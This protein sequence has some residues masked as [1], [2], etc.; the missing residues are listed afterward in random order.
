MEN[1]KNM[2][3][4]FGLSDQQAHIF[5]MLCKYWVKPASSIAKMMGGERTN[6]YKTLQSMVANGRI[7][8]T[9][10]QGI[11]QFFVAK[12]NVF[13]HQ[14]AL[15]KEY[16]QETEKILPLL[17]SE[18]NK[19]DEERISQIPTMNFF[20]WKQG[21]DNLFDDMYIQI[22]IH[23]YLFIKLLA[24]NTLESQSTASKNLKNYAASF[25]D[26]LKKEKIGVEAYLANG[27]MLLEN[28][29]KTS[30]IQDLNSLPAWS[31]AINIFV[32]GDFVYIIIFKNIPFGIKFESPELAN[33]V[34]F[35]LNQSEKSISSSF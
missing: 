29:L 33:V 17:E 19:F 20:E 18:L 9:K 24:T 23:H 14:I 7:A 13:T 16:I 10:K 32:F 6:I 34:H 30:N 25:F 22:I 12:K 21:I 27:I 35:L 26:K 1:L 31:S 3:V 28:M 2:I 5:I 15:Q 4:K 11:R 8:E